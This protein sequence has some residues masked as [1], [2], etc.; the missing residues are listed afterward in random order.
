MKKEKKRY[1]AFEIISDENFNKKNVIREIWDQSLEILGEL[2]TAK[3]KF[4][5]IDY[6]EEKSIGIFKVSNDYLEELRFVLA[7]IKDLNGERV[8][9][10]SLKSSGIIRN[11]K[12]KYFN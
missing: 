2:N 8:I 11:L 1:L 12:D 4:W 7:S 5:L 3:S 6:D 9:F 10:K